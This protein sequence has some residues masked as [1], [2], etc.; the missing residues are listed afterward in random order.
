V[1]SKFTKEEQAEAQL[2][3]ARAA[4]AVECWATEGIAACMNRFNSSK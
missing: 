2:T 3:I 1:L 4:D